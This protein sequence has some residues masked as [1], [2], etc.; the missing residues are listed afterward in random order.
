MRVSDI[1]PLVSNGG[2]RRPVDHAGDEPSR[3]CLSPNFRCADGVELLDWLSVGFCFL[4]TIGS[5]QRG[6]LRAVMFFVGDQAAAATWYRDVV[7]G[8]GE[9]TEDQGYYFV[10]VEGVEVGFHPADP[11]RNP[12]GRSVVAYFATDHLDEARSAAIQAGAQHHRGPLDISEERA[13]CQ[14]ID[15]FGNVFGLDGHR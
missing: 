13:I 7:V 9:V 11:D 1:N 14:L 5:S 15:P 4:M 6:P 8:A 2:P 10:E 12:P 3:G